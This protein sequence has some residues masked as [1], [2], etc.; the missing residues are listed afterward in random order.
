MCGINISWEELG[1][2]QGRASTWKAEAEVSRIRAWP[3]KGSLP[4]SEETEACG[5]HKLS[6][7]ASSRAGLSVCL[8][9]DAGHGAGAQAA[10][11]VDA[12]SL[13]PQPQSP[14]CPA[15]FL[16]GPPASPGP[17]TPPGK[18]KGAPWWPRPPPASSHP[19]CCPA[20]DMGSF[21]SFLHPRNSYT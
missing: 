4:C 3:P 9:F 18:S 7:Q 19:G 15:G 13:G 11:A 12:P 5:G 16:L 14:T 21:P 1:L 17:T 2:F 20:G 6:L 8:S 10:W